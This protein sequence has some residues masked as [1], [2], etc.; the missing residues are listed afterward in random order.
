MNNSNLPLYANL[1]EVLITK[2]ANGELKSGDRLPSHHTLCEQ[3]SVSYMTMRRAISEL[4]HEGVL[5]AIQGKGIFVAEN[6]QVVE[7]SGI[8]SF[9]EDMR[10]RGLVASAKLIE[11]NIIYAST[12]MVQ[13]L[14][15]KVGEPLVNIRRLRLANDQPIAIQSVFIPQM[16]CPDILNCDFN[17]VSLYKLFTDMYHLSITSSK[18]TVGAVLASAEDAEWLQI[19]LPAPLLVTERITYLADGSPLEYAR[20]LY[21]ADRYQIPLNDQALQQ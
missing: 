21:C 4:T 3:F 18:G 14:G 19:K 9:T 10:R 1:K 5:V 11:S 20:S 16:F 17:Q 7:L 2:I 15:V 6:K 12:V 13:V 8:Q